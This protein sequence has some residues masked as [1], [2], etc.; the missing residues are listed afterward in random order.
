[1]NFKEKKALIIGGTSG[2][3]RHLAVE[4]LHLGASVTVTGRK[5]PNIDGVQFLQCDYQK[6]GIQCLQTELCQ[7]SLF[8]CD[9]LIFCYGPFVQKSLH[10]T[11]AKDWEDMALSNY[12]IPGYAVSAAL[13][14]MM[15]RLYGRIILFGGTRTDAVRPYKTNA[16]YA[17]AKTGLSVLVKSVAAEYGAFGITCNAILPGFTKN[18]PANTNCVSEETLCAH[19]IHLLSHP[20][21]NGVLLTVDRGWTP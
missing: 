13:P 8:E 15:E 9:I 16:A 5:N 4:L 11:T 12:A 17:G 1:M 20:E 6:N 10:K 14:Q 19:A 2:T 18:P 21:L 3:G 7:S